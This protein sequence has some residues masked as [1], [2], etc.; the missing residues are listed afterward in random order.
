MNKTQFYDIYDYIYVPF[1]Q[2]RAFIITMLLLF[3]LLTAISIF[4]IIR[5]RRKRQKE[6][7]VPP[8]T[9]TLEKLE[10]LH[11]QNYQ[12]KEEFKLFYFSITSVMKRY[13][14]KR[15]SHNVIEKTDEELIDY[16][17]QNN[18]DLTFISQLDGILQGSLFIKF[19]NAQ[20]LREQ[21]QKDLNAMIE[22]VKSTIP[23]TSTNQK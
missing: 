8:W 12:T 22:L 17:Q 21:A 9:L 11:P 1:W 19:A 23:Q 6:K 10:K 15:F 5:Y 3:A 2:T 20:A 18:F 13:I 7:P 4:L 16:L 14:Q